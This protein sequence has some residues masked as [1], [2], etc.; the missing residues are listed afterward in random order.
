MLSEQTLQAHSGPDQV[1]MS[2]LKVDRF[3]TPLI[4]DGKL[5]QILGPNDL[6]ESVP[7][8]LVLC[9]FT[10]SFSLESS[11]IEFWVNTS[12]IKDGFKQFKVLKISVAKIL[13]FLISTEGLLDS[14]NR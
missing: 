10:K 2:L 3:P 7:Y 14:F 9:V 4:S 11:L 12:F 8:R 6:K 5:F 13:N 1:F